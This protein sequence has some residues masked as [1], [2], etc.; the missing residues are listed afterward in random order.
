MHRCVH[1]RLFRRFDTGELRDDTA[2]AGDEDAVG[3][4]QNFR[5]VGGNHYDGQTF[6]GDP[7]NELM[8]FGDGAD[9][10]AAR[11]LIENDEFRQLRERLGDRLSVD[12]RPTIRRPAHPG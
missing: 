8:N 10:D 3:Q 4:M 6:V 7:V 11:W 1:D 5:Q 2:L 12:F 9:I